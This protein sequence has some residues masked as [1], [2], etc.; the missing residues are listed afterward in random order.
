MKRLVVVL[1]ALV[2][3]PLIGLA[4]SVSSNLVIQA[5]DNWIAEKAQMGAAEVRLFV[6]IEGTVGQRTTLYY[7]KG[8]LLP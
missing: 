6:Q 5:V 3:V 2:A 7:V 4:E 8:D 1:L